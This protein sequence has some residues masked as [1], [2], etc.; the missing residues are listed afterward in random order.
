[1]E[2]NI[3]QIINLALVGGIIGCVFVLWLFL[4]NMRLVFF[5]ALSIPISV[6]GFQLLLRFWYYY[7]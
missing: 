6:Y 2:N 7:Q 1:M 4:K 5:I 3:N